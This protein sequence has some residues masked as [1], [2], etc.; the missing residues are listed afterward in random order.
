LLVETLLLSKNFK[1][2]GVPHQYDSAMNPTLRQRNKINFRFK[3]KKAE[4]MLK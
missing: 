1:G 3:V 4:L 2:E